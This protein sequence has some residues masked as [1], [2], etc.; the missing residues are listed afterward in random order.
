MTAE[1][2]QLNFDHHTRLLATRT[3]KWPAINE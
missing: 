1:P 2:D 3:I